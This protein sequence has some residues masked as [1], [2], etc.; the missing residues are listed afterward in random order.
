MMRHARNLVLFLVV[1]ATLLTG[2]E[3]IQPEGE[4]ECPIH[5]MPLTR[6]LVV[7]RSG[8][9][10]SEYAK[11]QREEFPYCGTIYDGRLSPGA[12]QEITQRWICPKCRRAE[13]EWLREHR[14]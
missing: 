3:S 6:E 7:A 1:G 10:R 2:C 11:A 8:Y 4:R 9:P 14:W 5:K 13:N 12:P